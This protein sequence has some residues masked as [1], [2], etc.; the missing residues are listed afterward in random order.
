MLN[1]SLTTEG[2]L[3]MVFNYTGDRLNFGLAMERCRAAGMKVREQMVKLT[4]KISRL[5]G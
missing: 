5:K 4:L 1:L 3:V 2:V